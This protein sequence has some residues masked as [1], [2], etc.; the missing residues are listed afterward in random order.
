MVIL[1]I[2]ILLFST[3]VPKSLLD[4]NSDIHH[5]SYLSLVYVF[6]LMWQPYLLRPSKELYDS[7]LCLWINVLYTHFCYLL[8]F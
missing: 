7:L 3:I 1:L 8:Y 4:L 5:S 6:S 2:F